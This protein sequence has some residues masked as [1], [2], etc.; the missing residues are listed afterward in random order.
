MKYRRELLIPFR[1]FVSN[2]RR[3]NS[4]NNVK[5]SQNISLKSNEYST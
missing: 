3:T 2:L 4:T 5:I 1:K